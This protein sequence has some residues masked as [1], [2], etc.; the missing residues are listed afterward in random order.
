MGPLDCPADFPICGVFGC[1]GSNFDPTPYSPPCGGIYQNCQGGDNDGLA[2]FT[3][4]DCAGSACIHRPDHPFGYPSICIA[5]AGTLDYYFYCVALETM[6]SSTSCAASSYGGTYPL[7]ISAHACG[8]FTF[9]ID[10]GVSATYF[11]FEDGQYESPSALES[12][13]IEL[14]PCG[15][16]CHPDQTCAVAGESFCDGRWFPED[17]CGGDLCT[18]G[19]CCAADGGCSV[20]NEENCQGVLW[21]QSATCNPNRCIPVP[22]RRA[23][24]STR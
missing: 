8:T 6:A 23:S 10:S 22:V 13:V 11:R 18:R 16:C 19:A 7:Q 12:L 20:V 21:T 24:R 5:F 2:C 4:L 14:P 9:D 15:A 1:V 17:S 3:S